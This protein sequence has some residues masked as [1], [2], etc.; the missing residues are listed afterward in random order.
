MEYFGSPCPGTEKASAERLAIRMAKRGLGRE[1][2]NRLE[3]QRSQFAPA[4]LGDIGSIRASKETDKAVMPNHGE[5][6]DRQRLTAAI[7]GI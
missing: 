5:A 1:F 7:D 3:F 4:G 2:E 6:N